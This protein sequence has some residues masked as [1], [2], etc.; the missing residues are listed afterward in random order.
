MRATTMWALVLLVALTVV[1]CSTA[2][3]RTGSPATGSETQT[4]APAAATAIPVLV[5]TSAAAPGQVAVATRASGNTQ[6]A[7]SD[8][9]IAAVQAVIQK[10]DQEQQDAFAKNDPTI[11]QDTATSSYYSQLPQ[12]NSDM[13]NGGV[14]VIKLVKIDWGEV[15]LTNPTTAQA[16][17]YETWETTYTDGSSDQARELNVYTLVQEQGIWKIQADDHPN[18]GSSTSGGSPASGPPG[19]TA[20]GSPTAVVPPA[21]ST[22]A[23]GADTSRNW[24]GYASTSGS[25]TAVRGTWTV[26]NSIGAGGFGTD[27]TW[28]GIGGA[29]SRDLIQAGTEEVTDRSGSVQWDAWIEM[30]PRSARPVQFAVKAGDSVTVSISQQSSGQW[31]IQFNNNTTGESYQTTVQYQSSLSSA[32][33]IEEAP[34]SG[35]RGG[36]ILPLDNFGTV[37]FSGGNADQNG[38]TVTI[39]QS[40]AK[41]LALTDS[42]G[43]ALVVPSSLTADGQGFLVSRAGSATTP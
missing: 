7:S 13:A 3:G 24:A 8:P 22:A 41:P 39:A 11:M 38:K 40:G 30:L 28:V 32:E 35:G 25:F 12:I 16:S 21:V 37:Q 5:P 23:P 20:P 15:K 6:P 34:T 17:A 26:P 14:S 9:A 43:S 33:W 42:A 18:S 19:S 31:L 29:T 10:A 36:R 27:A 4:S 1:G 2:L